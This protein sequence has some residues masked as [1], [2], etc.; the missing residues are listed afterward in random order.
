MTDQ[1]LTAY[2]I[3]WAHWCRTRKLFAPPVPPNILAQ[4]QPRKVS[5]TERDGPM[6]ADMSFFN[7]AVHGLA[8]VEQDDATAFVL[9]HY[10]GIRPVKCLY[11]ALGIGRQTFYDRL[12]RFAR[13]A[14]KAAATI[15]RVHLEHLAGEK[16]TGQTGQFSP[17]QK[18]D[19]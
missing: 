19:L 3:E 11:S 8:D 5:L 6:S 7:M 18:A 2:C 14:H 9:Y 15:K 10:Y 16:C 12:N 4:L 17:V 1:E 13:R